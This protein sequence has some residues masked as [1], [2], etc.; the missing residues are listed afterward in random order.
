E[1]SEPMDPAGFSLAIEPAASLGAPVWAFEDSMVSV[2]PAAPLS[3]STHYQIIVTGRDLG[4]RSLGGNPSFEFTTEPVPD[5]NPPTVSSTTPADNATGVSIA[6]VVTVTFSKPMDRATVSVTPA[7][8]LDLGPPTWDGAGRTVSFASAAALFVPSTSYTLTVAGQDEQAQAL[9]G[10]TTFTFR[11]GVSTDITRPTVVNT[12]PAAGASGVP[13]SATLSV[14]FSEPMNLVA[15][16]AAFSANPGV[17]CAFNW[18]APGTRLSCKPNVALAANTDYAVT[19]GTGAQDLA[20]NALAVPLAFTFAT[21]LTADLSPPTVVS[22]KPANGDTGVERNSDIVVIFS[23][24]MDQASAQA[25]FAIGGWATTGAFTWDAAGTTFT[26]RPAQSFSNGA[27]VSFTVGIGAKDL[28][29][30]AMAM[31]VS[32]SFKAAVRGSM[33]LYSA[34]MQDGYVTSVGT[35]NSIG[36]QMFAGDDLVNSTWRAFASFNLAGLPTNVLRIQSA[37]L[38]VYQAN[39][40]GTPYSLG[41]LTASSVSYGPLLSAAVYS[42]PVLQ[43]LQCKGL[44]PLCGLADEEQVLSTSF[45]AGNVSAVVSLKV[46]DDWANRASRGGL[47]QFRI[48]FPTG[49]NG[50]NLNDRLVMAAGEN[51]T[52]RPRLTVVYDIP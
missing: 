8:Y 26:Y 39:A 31:A 32:R 30:N 21:S 28:A 29:G 52:N 27:M 46:S 48:G 34:A 7:P 45:G 14:T 2:T 18:D 12:V 4:G 35:V 6:T 10:I 16:Q 19:V 15:T 24:A 40:A 51:L 23:E 33:T 44:P 9:T 22:T 37:T 20:G 38:F 11:T 41:A 49:T 42:T 13:V 47:S 17:A 25:A 3:Y 50:N 43:T 1:F 36:S 5:P